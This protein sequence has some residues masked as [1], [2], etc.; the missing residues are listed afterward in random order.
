MAG[1]KSSEYGTDNP[2]LSMDNLADVKT[3]RDRAAECRAL[4]QMMQ[5]ER[6]RETYLHAAEMYETIAAQKE[7]LARPPAGSG[8]AK[9]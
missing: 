7:V 4:A 8:D 6:A 9:G 3:L 2:V 1:R 5:N